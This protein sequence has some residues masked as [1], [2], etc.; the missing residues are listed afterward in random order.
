[1]SKYVRFA[2]PELFQDAVRHARATRR[3]PIPA[4][5]FWGGVTLWFVATFTVG[6][7]LLS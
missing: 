4:P 1:M 7:M 2:E 3:S 5:V 6:V